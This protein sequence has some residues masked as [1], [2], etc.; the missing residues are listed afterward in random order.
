MFLPS[1][2]DL[3]L[4]FAS[5][6]VSFKKK[7]KSILFCFFF[8]LLYCNLLYLCICKNFCDIETSECWYD[9]TKENKPVVAFDKLNKSDA[10]VKSI[11][12]FSVEL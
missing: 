9:A 8:F 11:F 1:V 7:K 6:K 5:G 3:F 10:G 2:K 12:L 4:G